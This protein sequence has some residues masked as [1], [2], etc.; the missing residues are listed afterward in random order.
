MRAGCMIAARAA[1][2]LLRH[3]ARTA[4]AVLGV[5]VAAAM[6]LDMIMLADGMRASF[7][8]M[9]DVRGFQLRLSPR[10]TLP[11]D[12][13]A[14]IGGAGEIARLLRANPDIETVAPV[15]GAALHVRVP[16]TADVSV[17]GL[18]VE[19]AVQGDYALVRGRE[20][21]R[22]D[23]LVAN[24]LLLR[25]TRAR[26]GDTLTVAVGYD[27][28]LRTARG[29]RRLVVVGEGRFFYLAADQPAAALPIATLQAMGGP[30]RADRVSLFMVRARPGADVE[31][32]R[33]WIAERVPR[34]TVLSTATAMAAVDQ[35]LSYFRQ[36]AV[37]LGAVSL[38]VGFL[39]VT[40]LVTVSVNER[41][42]EIAVLRAIGVARS[43]VVRQIVLEGLVLSVA[44]AVVGL[45]LGLVT[46]RYLN[47]ILKA[48]PG[49]PASIDFFLFQ[50]R[51]AAAA[52]GLLVVT[53]LVAG[54][55]PAW[56]AASLPIA[57]TLRQEAVA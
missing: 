4:L 20:A 54:A 31:R 57:R 26:L 35:R 10:G 14:T 22:P 23:E 38:V 44:G 5:A 56:R 30:E 48:F 24:A 29:T 49:L 41:V 40:T 37:I 12:T 16:G 21:A 9:L 18:G 11:F 42:G 43:R 32:V 1:A 19:P 53:G 25:R 17:V 27:P 55:F 7:R 28:Q 33:A 51:D 3:R 50:P 15:L 39:L 13:E 8:A 47:G 2:S 6:L 36:L 34:V 52:L 45:G 46:A